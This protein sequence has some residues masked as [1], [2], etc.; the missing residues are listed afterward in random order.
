[1]GNADLVDGSADGNGN[2]EHEDD[3]EGCGGAAPVHR[4]GADGE[5]R[6]V[7]RRGEARRGGGGISEEWR[8]GWEGW[9]P[10]G[11]PA[12]GV[13]MADE[14]KSAEATGPPDPARSAF[15]S[16][17]TRVGLRSSLP[18]RRR[19]LPGSSISFQRKFSLV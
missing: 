12:C 6:S 5:T 17:A 3:E 10:A 4:D 16:R 14:L 15:P 13:G 2:G 8:P 19:A 11:R 7:R 1:M 18:C 9:Q